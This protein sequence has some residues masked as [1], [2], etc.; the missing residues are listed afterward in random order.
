MP[1]AQYQMPRF[2]FIFLFFGPLLSLTVSASPIHFRLVTAAPAPQA[3]SDSSL[4][5]V[6][7]SDAASRTAKG[8]LGPLPVTEHLRRAS[9]YMTNRAIAEAREHWQAV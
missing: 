1:S 2:T 8:K 5:A 3:A 9:I 6:R 7:R 4:A